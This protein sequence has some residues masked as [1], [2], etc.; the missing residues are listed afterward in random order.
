MH[1]KRGSLVSDAETMKIAGLKPINC[2][3]ED[4]RT[5]NV[6]WSERERETG[7]RISIEVS[8]QGILE[9]GFSHLV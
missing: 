1:V 7:G 6:P 4:S 9:K 3:R 5:L 8:S 2:L